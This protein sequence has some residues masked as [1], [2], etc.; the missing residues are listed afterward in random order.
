V[1][2]KTV[3]EN[4]SV[5]HSHALRPFLRC[6]FS[7]HR[8]PGQHR[9][10]SEGLTRTN[11]VRRSPDMVITGSQLPFNQIERRRQ[12]ATN[13]RHIITPPYHLGL[14]Q[15]GYLVAYKSDECHR[16]AACRF[17]LSSFTR[18]SCN[19]ISRCRNKVSWAHS[20]EVKLGLVLS[21]G[22]NR[23]GVFRGKLLHLLRKTRCTYQHL[24]HHT[25]SHFLYQQFNKETNMVHFYR[26]L[27]QSDIPRPGRSSVHDASP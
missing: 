7:Q 21:D 23:C 6:R 24:Q 8:A 10:T 27:D 4:Y 12:L 9:Y 17:E 20:R 5:L 25:S 16:L 19:P 15:Q 3:F 1:H 11:A 26:S 14:S 18:V 2:P 22:T 13:Y